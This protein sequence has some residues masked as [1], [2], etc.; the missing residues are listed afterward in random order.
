[1][2]VESGNITIKKTSDDSA[3][4]TIDVTSSKVTG[5]GTTVIEINPAKAFASST[6]YYVLIDGT[7]FDDV[8]GNSYAG[9]SST[10]ALSFTSQD[11]GNPYLTSSTPAHQGTDIAVDANIVLNFSE[12]VDAESGNIVIKK[13]SDD[14]I[15]E[16]IDVT[17]SLVSGSGSNQITVNPSSDFD[18]QIKYYVTID[19]T[20]FDD[21]SGNSYVGIDNS[22]IKIRFTTADNTN[23]TLT[24]SSPGDDATSV[25]T[26][27]SLVINFSED[28]DAESGNITLYDSNDTEIQTY[29]V[30]DTA[31]VMKSSG[32]TYNIDISADITTATSYYIQIAASAFD[33]AAGNSYAGIADSTTLNFTTSSTNCGCVAGQIVNKNEEVQTGV[34][35]QL[36]DA[37]NNLIDSDVTDD[38]GNY[39]LFPST[40]GTYKVLFVNSSSKKWK[41]KNAHGKFHGRYVE[42]IEFTTSCEEYENVDAILID[43]AG[44]VYD[45][46]T[47]SAL[48]GATV[49]LFYGDSIVD[50]NW[51]DSGVGTNTE[52]TSSDGQYTFVLNGNASTGTYTL[53]VEPPSGYIFESADIPAET[54]A[55]VPELGSGEETIQDQSTAPTSSETTTYYLSFTFTIENVAAETSN[56]VIHNHIPVDPIAASGKELVNKVTTPLTKVLKQDF[57]DTVSG[58]MNDF[59]NIARQSVRRLEKNNIKYCEDMESNSSL[60]EVK[61]LKAIEIW[62]TK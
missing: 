1:M 24:S 3:F 4:E 35:V 51:L 39:D 61:F 33:D 5:T 47:R 55:Y 54:S 46:N 16:T 36:L 17:G 52:I 40:S 59:S 37:S 23:P 45:S 26:L 29:D 58:Q 42:E 10:T 49:R 22:N 14:S 44:V 9:I 12:S 27:A 8:N 50:N 30:T 60:D 57:H 62:S 48:S 41:A 56:G 28:V 25:N 38:E 31:I 43:P 13:S 32:S 21:T 53:E 11:T 6:E 34:T 19:A 2:D 20:A 18:E 15:V 7:A